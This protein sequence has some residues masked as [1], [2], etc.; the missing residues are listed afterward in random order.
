VTSAASTVFFYPQPASLAVTDGS[1]HGL[2][3]AT[4]PVTLTA[5]FEGPYDGT[6]RPPLIPLGLASDIPIPP[7]LSPDGFAASGVSFTSPIS[8]HVV[9]A[10]A[11]CGV[12]LR[13]LLDSQTP[14][15]LSVTADGHRI[16]TWSVRETNSSK[17]W[18]ESDFELPATLGGL[19][20]VT[21]TP[22][23]A[24]PETMYGLQTL[25]RRCP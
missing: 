25:S 1:A 23:G 21:L 18:K 17:R 6:F 2:T 12:V 10:P 9:A 4:T 20:N 13:R 15:V 14:S 11:N 3:G 5:Y 16:G 24:S 22:I 7:Q 8:F 19:V